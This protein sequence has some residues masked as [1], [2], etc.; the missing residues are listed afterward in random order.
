MEWYHPLQLRIENHSCGI[1][2]YPLFYLLH[3]RNHMKQNKH[4]Q[5]QLWADYFYSGCLE[6]RKMIQVFLKT[7]KVES[8]ELRIIISKKDK[9]YYL[10]LPCQSLSKLFYEHVLYKDK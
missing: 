7:D 6:F 1:S 2:R 8:K 3:K 4:H 9:R 5:Q 10:L